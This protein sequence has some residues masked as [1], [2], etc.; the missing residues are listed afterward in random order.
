MIV[1]LACVVSPLVGVTAAQAAEI[2][3]VDSTGDVHRIDYNGTGRPVRAP[4]VTNGDFTKVTYRHLRHRVAIHAE[5][6][7]LVAPQAGSGGG[8]DSSMVFATRMRTNERA[9][10]IGFTIADPSV[11]GGDAFLAK[12]RG[13]VRCDVAHRIDYE[14]NTITMSIPRRCLSGP[15]WVRFT[16]AHAAYD[17]NIETTDHPHDNGLVPTAWTS[18]VRRAR[19]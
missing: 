2:T 13:L 12:R 19:A 17:G 15:R 9:Y 3:V 16:S 11:P 4:E 8:D 6:V 14:A 10:R 7:D 5:Y 18:K 1:L